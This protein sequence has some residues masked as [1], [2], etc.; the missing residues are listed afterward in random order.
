MQCDAI[1]LPKS[2]IADANTIQMAILQVP[3]SAENA[4]VGVSQRAAETLGIWQDKGGLTTRQ[5]D[6]TVRKP[7]CEIAQSTS[8]INLQGSGPEQL[9]LLVDHC[10]TGISNLESKWALWKHYIADK[11]K[12]DGQILKAALGEFTEVGLH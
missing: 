12:V 4:S 3:I 11:N 8:I 7:V 10:I 6:N 1:R 2:A 9:N 5:I